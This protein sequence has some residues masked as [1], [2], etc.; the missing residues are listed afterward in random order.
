[1]FALIIKRSENAFVTS[2]CVNYFKTV[3]VCFSSDMCVSLLYFSILLKGYQIFLSLN[4]L[5]KKKVA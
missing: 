1:M 3:L 5:K 4:C 2:P